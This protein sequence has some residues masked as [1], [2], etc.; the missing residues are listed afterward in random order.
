[1]ILRKFS[2][3]ISISLSYNSAPVK[4][5]SIP[6]NTGALSY[7]SLK[8]YIFLELVKTYLIAMKQ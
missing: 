2:S 3:I 5:N 7:L 8:T 1:M 4:S 6:V